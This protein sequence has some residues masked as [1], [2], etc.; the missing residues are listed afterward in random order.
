MR[1]LEVRIGQLLGPASRGGDRKSDQV[2]RDELDL[3]P[4]ERNSFRKMAEHPEIVDAVIAESSDDEPPSR[5]KV[6]GANY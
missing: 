5:R 3:S 4:Q 1:R 2:N 6:L